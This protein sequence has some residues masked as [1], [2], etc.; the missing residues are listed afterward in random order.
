MIYFL[1]L[2]VVHLHLPLFQGNGVLVENN[3][4]VIGDFIINRLGRTG[5]TVFQ[6]TD[7]CSGIL[8][9]ADFLAEIRDLAVV[10]LPANQM[11]AIVDNDS[12]E[13]F[14][15]SL[16]TAF[17]EIVPVYLTIKYQETLS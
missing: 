7:E 12:Q 4:I 14:E 2:A 5:E 9:K 3:E 17:S 16:N 1:E 10:L 13:T 6:V 8:A 11:L 15:K